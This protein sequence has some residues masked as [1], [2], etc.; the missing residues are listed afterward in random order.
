MTVRKWHCT[1]NLTAVVTAYTRSTLAQA[2][3]NTGME[4]GEDCASVMRAHTLGWLRNCPVTLKEIPSARVQEPHSHPTP[5]SVAEIWSCW[6][7]NHKD[8]VQSE[9]QSRARVG[10]SIPECCLPRSLWLWRGWGKLTLEPS[11]QE[12]HLEFC[13]CLLWSWGWNAGFPLCKPHSF[14]ATPPALQLD[15]YDIPCGNLYLHKQE[16]LHPHQPT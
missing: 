10:G 3:Q 12:Q 15:F 2:G 11:N 7:E 1:R 16:L 5:W 4:T 13:L 14:W 9:F 6:F 8:E